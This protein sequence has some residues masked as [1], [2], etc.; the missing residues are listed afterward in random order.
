MI[1][2]F[3][4]TGIGMGSFEKFSNSFY[5]LIYYRPGQIPHAHNLFLQIAIDLGIPGLIAWLGI[6]ITTFYTA[7]RTFIEGNRS[8]SSK[9]MGISAGLLASQVALIFHGLTDAVVWGMVKPAPLVWVV[10]GTI[11]ALGNLE[12]SDHKDLNIKGLSSYKQ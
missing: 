11:I 3:P 6:I 9:I 8:I 12:N 4:F 1:R 10:L 7:F 2:D 5:P